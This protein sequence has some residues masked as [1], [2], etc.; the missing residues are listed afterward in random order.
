MFR[1]RSKTVLAKALAK[2]IDTS[3]ARIQCTPDLMPADI[4][5]SSV[6]LP[7][8]KQFE[9]R[10]GP[11]ISSI[12][13]VDEL[14]RATPRTQAALLEAMSEK[15]VSADGKTYALP[16][17][18]FVIATENPV[19]SEGTFPLPEAQKD[20]FMI[21]QSIGYPDQADE[22]LII[23]SQRRVDNPVEDIKAALHTGYFEMS[24]EGLQIH[25]DEAVLHYIMSLVNSH[26]Q[27]KDSHRRFAPGSIALYKAAQAP[28]VYGKRL[29]S[30]GRCKRTGASGFRKGLYFSEFIVRV[31]PAILCLRNSLQRSGSF[32]KTAYM[33]NRKKT[34][35]AGSKTAALLL[36]PAIILLFVPGTILQYAAAFF[37]I[38]LSVSL[39]YSRIIR[40]S[41]VVN[42]TMDELRSPRFEFLEIKLRIENRSF[43]PVFSLYIDDKPGILSISA[44]SGRALFHLRKRESILFTYTVNG[45]TR[46]EYYAGGRN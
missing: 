16:S 25:V 46:G 17:P 6:F 43:L 2:S 22:E 33:T 27:I 28:P 19:E 26:G 10:K 24:G 9:F 32:G 20:R 14:N 18:F 12:I 7:D 45:N 8:T 41:I 29:C 36:L 3:F 40:S 11:L 1:V 15:Q 34:V 5:G 4:T 37:F 44:D 21:C 35:S 38:L 39:A 23:V 42:H 31:I 13:L 30:P